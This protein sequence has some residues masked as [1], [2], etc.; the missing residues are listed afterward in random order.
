[1]SIGSFSLSAN[2]IAALIEEFSP[3]LQA[4]KE[5]M[6]VEHSLWMP[7]TLD[8]E[9]YCTTMESLAWPREISREQ[10]KRISTFKEKFCSQH[11]Q[12]LLFGISDIGE[13]GYWWDYGTISN[14]FHS[15]LKLTDRDEEAKAMRSFFAI[16][17]N[18]PSAPNAPLQIDANSIILGSSIKAGN[19][20]NSILIGVTASNLNLEHSVAIN[21]TFDTAVATTNLFYNVVEEEELYTRM[22]TVRADIFLKQIEDSIKIFTHLGRDGKVDWNTPV[23]SNPY[24]YA[25]LEALNSP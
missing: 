5:M 20:A 24:S 7:L 16:Q 9:T 4:K 19:I 23:E 8:L 10:H 12:T 2:M 13:D 1:M 15:L 6:N 22:Y 21:S 18:A 17:K 14:Y 3:E 25:E 11:P